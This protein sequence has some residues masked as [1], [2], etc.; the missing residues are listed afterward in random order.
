M[1]KVFWACGEAY[2]GSGRPS[3]T[4]VEATESVGDRPDTAD[5][6]GDRPYPF[7]GMGGFVLDGPF[8]TEAEAESYCSDSVEATE[9]GFDHWADT[10]GLWVSD[11]EGF[12]ARI[13]PFGAMK[14]IQQ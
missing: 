12:V 4:W 13:A 5:E 6:E 10:S 7:N 1:T 9:T 11:N 14:G 2:S 8:H 3:R